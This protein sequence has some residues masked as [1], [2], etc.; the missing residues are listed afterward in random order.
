M[1]FNHLLVM[2]IERQ[3]LLYMGEWFNPTASTN[4]SPP[5]A[6]LICQVAYIQI[7]NINISCEG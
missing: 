6:V 4:P 2:A 5:A 7:A 1:L 3:L